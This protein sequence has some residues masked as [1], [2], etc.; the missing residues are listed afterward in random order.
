MKIELS[1]NNRRERIV[2]PVNPSEIEISETNLNE[3]VNILNLGEINL[4]GKRGLVTLSIESFFP[5]KNS[6]FAKGRKVRD[7]AEYKNLIKNWK[8]S[9]KPVRAIIPAAEFNIAMAIDSF[10]YTIR[11]GTNDIKYKLELSEYR[12]LNVSSIREQNKKIKKNGLKERV[13]SKKK[14]SVYTV[15]KGDTLFSIAK[16]ILGDGSKFKEIYATNKELIDSR[17]KEGH[18][19][20]IHIGQ[21]LVLPG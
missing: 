20:N 8:E 19:Y 9:G 10:T 11:E 21:R 5:G 7:A 12:F 16:R 4:I 13:S 6:P 17:N 3:K 15:K 1:F 14:E 2:L 18:R